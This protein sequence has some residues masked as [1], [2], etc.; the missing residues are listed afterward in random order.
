M[1]DFIIRTDF[2]PSEN[3]TPEERATMAEVEIRL[4][5]EVLTT[6]DDSWAQSV[7]TSVRVACYPLAMWFA[8][9]WWRQLH[10]T[11]STRSGLSQSH[12]W[13]MSHE[14]RAVGSGFLLP[15]VTFTP[16]GESV[17]VASR[18]S[19]RV[20]A[21]PVRFLADCAGAVTAKAFEREVERFVSSVVARLR[22]RGLTNTDLEVLWTQ[23]REEAS[24]PALARQRVLEA[25]LGFDPDEA[26]DAVLSGFQELERISSP[27]IVDE[28]SNAASSS[29]VLRQDP[30]LILE[31]VEQARHGG[32]LGRFAIPDCAPALAGR[33]WDRG[34]KCARALRSSIGK[35][36]GRLSDQDLEALVGTHFVGTPASAPIGLAIPEMEGRVRLLFRRTH[37]TGRRFEV[38]RVVGARALGSSSSWLVTSDAA[39]ASQK[40][41]RAFAA[42]FLVPIDELVDRL[43]G[44]YSQDSIEQAAE[45]YQVSALTISSH[46][47]NNGHIPPEDVGVAV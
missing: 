44:D 18:P 37:P 27:Q 31:A 26:P 32:T 2:Y 35:L 11:G 40:A 6:V 24:S 9:A 12:G 7:R 43:Q 14:L 1:S 21:E 17:E 22:A 5:N 38:A 36:E 29:P 19:R 8:G 42:E 10:E 23:V 3:G 4:G 34:R 20:L 13:R 39:T 46:L 41:Q 47:A 33:P 45:L 30:R 16:D 28:L 25:E 15:R